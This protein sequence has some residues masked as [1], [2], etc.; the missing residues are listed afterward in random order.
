MARCLVVGG[1]GFIGSHLSERLLREG[2]EVADLDRFKSFNDSFG[3]PAGDEV[4][5]E[6]GRL[7][8][9]AIRPHDMVARYGGEEFA[10]LLPG[11]DAAGAGRVPHASVA[12]AAGD[13][14]HRNRRGLGGRHG[15]IVAATCRC[16][17]VPQ[18]AGWSRSLHAGC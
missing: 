3:H 13:D 18:Q 2:Y 12:V 15:A 5:R 9:G 6:T 16:G 17:A 14:Q 7:L 1:N 4:L 11:A 8:R 10:I